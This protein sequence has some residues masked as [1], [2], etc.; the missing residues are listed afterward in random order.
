MASKYTWA[1]ILANILE[2]IYMFQYEGLL[3]EFEWYL[4]VY[5]N[6]NAMYVLIMDSKISKKNA[7]IAGKDENL[8]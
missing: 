5:M 2:Q 4:I 6:L 7:F 3:L 1:N 8:V